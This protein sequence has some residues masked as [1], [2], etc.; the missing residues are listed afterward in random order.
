MNMQQK[1]SNYLVLVNQENKIPDNWKEI[2]ELVDA[3]NTYG[4]DIK[5][6]KETYKNYK[7]LKL[8]LEK[9]AFTF[10]LIVCIVR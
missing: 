9:K 2:V 10:Y 3:K 5:I 6:E 4:Q 8:D 1:Q 7:K